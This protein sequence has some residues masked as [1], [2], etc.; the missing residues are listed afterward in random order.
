MNRV[1]QAGIGVAIAGAVLLTPRGPAQVQGAE[2]CGPYALTYQFMRVSSP[3][4]PAAYLA[5][6]L[7]IV[8]PGFRLPWLI[9]AWR[10]LAGQPLTTAERAAIWSPDPPSGTPN[11][12]GTVFGTQRWLRVSRAAVNEPEQYRYIPQTAET[13]A[14]A[15]YDNCPGTAF[16]S[17]AA[18]LQARVEALGATDPT[19]KPWIEAQ[20]LVWANCGHKKGDAAKVPAPL[21]DA[22]TPLARADRAY[23]IA[24]A[25]FYAGDWDQAVAG[26]RAIAA[27]RT[28]PWRP[29]GEYL[30]AR[31]RLRQGMIGGADGGI[32]AGALDQA[33]A[34][35]A[36]VAADR[37]S[38]LSASA[39]GLKRFAELRRR[40]EALRADVLARLLT[41]SPAEGFDETIAEYRY[42]FLR[43]VPDPAKAG[44]TADPL[45]DWV[46]TLRSTSPEA[47]THAIARW[48]EH[49]QVA[50]LVAAM[51]MLPPKHADEAALVD[52]ARAVPAASPAYPTLAFHRARLLVREGRLD[53]ARGVAAEM[54]TASASWP[55][56]ARNQLRALELR[57]ATT[58][59]AFLA[60]AAQA[61][62]G[63]DADEGEEVA[64]LQTSEPLAISNDALDMVNERLPLSRLVDAAEAKAWPAVL[65]RNALGAA[66][67]RALLLD[68]AEA[69]KR[70]DRDVRATW[71]ELGPEID[72]V[73][74]ASAADERRFVVARLLLRHPGLRPF[75]TGGQRRMTLDWSASPP[76][77]T[78]DALSDVDELR[79]NWWCGLSP[80]PALVG[81]FVT[82]GAYQPGIYARTGRRLDPITA[83]LYDDPSI[84]PWPAFVTAEER[85]R[86]EREW[87]T[88]AAIGAA[89][90][91]LGNEVLAWAAAHPTDAR[92]AEALHRVV[93]ATRSGCTGEKTGEV[94]KAAFTVLHTRFPASEWAK[95]TPYWFR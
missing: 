33:I 40:P 31:A 55:E 64:T 44:R 69:L 3:D 15:Y 76:P 67:T 10:H 73:A 50:W 14:G 56:S 86:V 47:V 89:P 28:S 88:L 95:K 52:A 8:T 83:S 57:L 70:L 68:D 75:M 74:K 59:E 35:F 38:A 54:R 78:Y 34:G 9:G 49:Q 46:D 27:D 90:D 29:Y 66:F 85:A 81:T 87:K 72:A 12:P 36:T 93:R 37:T 80:S 21:L 6:R 25:Y 60:A 42:L 2:A 63:F 1:I 43:D 77:A 5:G 32:D 65:R 30:A 22:A 18:T 71:P 20:E 23:Q 24:S 62:V 82:F 79:D 45:T 91:Y 58:P 13:P 53:A 7:G 51:L 48:R 41:P 94:S 26:F 19:I 16:E 39:A 92:L 11:P 17:A 4:D 84:V 61:P